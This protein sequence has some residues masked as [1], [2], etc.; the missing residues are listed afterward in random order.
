MAIQAGQL[1]D[2]MNLAD[3]HPLRVRL[4]DG[5]G[6]Q[7]TA[8]QQIRSCGRRAYAPL[9]EFLRRQKKTLID[10]LE[11]PQDLP[12]PYDFLASIS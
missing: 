10:V 3:Y 4:R 1:L 2:L 12:G 7:S 9:A 8:A 5:S 11:S 6:A